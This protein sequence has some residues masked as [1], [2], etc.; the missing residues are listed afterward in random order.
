MAGTSEFL[1]SPSNGE[2]TVYQELGSEILPDN[3]GSV[4]PIDGLLMW[5]NPQAPCGATAFKTVGVP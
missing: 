1:A 2:A 5:G 4:I 3:V